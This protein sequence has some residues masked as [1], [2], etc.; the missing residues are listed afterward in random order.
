MRRPISFLVLLAAVAAALVAV[1]LPGPSASAAVARQSAPAAAAPA[2]ATA[3]KIVYVRPVTVSGKPAPGWS[4]QRLSGSVTCDGTSPSAV[5]PGITSC[6]PTAYGLKACWKS[7]RHTV[8][9]VRDARVRKLVRVRYDGA[10]PSVEGPV[11]PAPLD[12]VLTDGRTCLIRNGGAWGSPAQHPQWVGFDS[13]TRK[14]SVYGPGSSADGINR[15]QSRWTVR[16][17]RS[18]PDPDGRHLVTRGVTTGWVVGT[19]AD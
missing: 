3:T 6:Y 17:W 8:L 16:I 14:A 5:N 15:S 2:P 7:A 4:V 19:A 12:L 18:G 10:Y 1:T 13:C 11:E 9:C